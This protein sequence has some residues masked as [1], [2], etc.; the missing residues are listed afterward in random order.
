MVVRVFCISLF[1]LSLSATLAADL[2]PIRLE[3]IE[4]ET[5]LRSVIRSQQLGLDSKTYFSTERNKRGFLRK[6]IGPL[7]TSATLNP[8][9]FRT[10]VKAELDLLDTYDRVK[11]GVDPTIILPATIGTVQNTANSLW[12]FTTD[13]DG[14]TRQYF[15]ILKRELNKEPTFREVQDRE[16][17]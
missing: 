13:I 5:D 15:D 11:D 10:Q 3:D 9:N 8:L 6:E 17:F 7:K 16:E 14:K 2:E 4:S 1:A 12:D